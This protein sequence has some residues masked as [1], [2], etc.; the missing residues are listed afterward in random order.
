ME[1]SLHV[2]NTY[3][4]SRFYGIFLNIG[5]QNHRPGI[6]LVFICR[7][8]KPAVLGQHS[9][10]IKQICGIWHQVAARQL[11]KS[12]YSDKSAS[13]LKMLRTTWGWPALHQPQPGD[14]VNTSSLF[15]F[16][17]T[18]SDFSSINTSFWKII[19]GS[20]VRLIVLALIPGPSHGT[21][22]Y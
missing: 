7:A 19:P 4:M 13:S 8:G 9:R 18:P 20:D 14:N 22:D 11:K 10:W 2:R 1:A 21:D 5:R 12:S 15:F 3:Q 6:S 16:N 17:V